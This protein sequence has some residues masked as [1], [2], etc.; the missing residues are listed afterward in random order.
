M[1]IY[2]QILLFQLPLL[3]LFVC[4]PKFNSFLLCVFVF[5]LYCVL[6]VLFLLLFYLNIQLCLYL[7]IKQN[8]NILFFV[9]HLIIV[10][11]SCS[12]FCL[13]LNLVW[14]FVVLYFVR[15]HFV[16]ILN[17]FDNEILFLTVFYGRVIRIRDLYLRNFCATQFKNFFFMGLLI[18]HL[19]KVN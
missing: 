17:Y 2:F 14:N 11:R 10:N 16:L 1:L 7:L 15:L 13:F 3:F 12:S 19:I 9:I 6:I 18:C 4:L 8:R 5:F